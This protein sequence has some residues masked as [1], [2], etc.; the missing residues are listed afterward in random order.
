MIDAYQAQEH[1]PD[2]FDD[3]GQ[4]TAHVVHAQRVEIGRLRDLLVQHGIDAGEWDDPLAI[5]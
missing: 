2:G 5:T 3:W 4:F 1:L